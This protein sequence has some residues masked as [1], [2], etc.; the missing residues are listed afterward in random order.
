MSTEP[1]VK[2]DFVVKLPSDGEQPNP[3]EGKSLVAE[4]AA[5]RSNVAQLCV[6]VRGLVTLQSVLNQAVQQLLKRDG[7]SGVDFAVIR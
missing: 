6:A 3:S 4:V 5:L 2:A 1:E 7:G